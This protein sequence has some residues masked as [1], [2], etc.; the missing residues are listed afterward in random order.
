MKRLNIVEKLPDRNSQVD[1]MWERLTEIALFARS[2]KHRAPADILKAFIKAGDELNK[3]MDKGE[4]SRLRGAFDYLAGA[5]RAVPELVLS[6]FAT[7][8]PQFYTM[9]TLL[10]SKDIMG[11][12]RP[13]EF[14]NKLIVARQILDGAKDPTGKID[15]HD[16]MSYFDAST[17][18][19]THPAR[20]EMRQDILMKPIDAQ[21]E[22]DEEE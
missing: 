7:D 5:Y 21:R 20:R 1:R 2:K 16:V 19:T 18:Q 8:Q 10:L 13:V 14:A 4:L 15:E 6:K 12:F 3:R 17:K 22:G 11:R 9:I